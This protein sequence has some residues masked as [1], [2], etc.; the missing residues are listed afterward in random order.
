MKKSA[1]ENTLNNFLGWME[2]YI[3]ISDK[4]IKEKS[5]FT[6]REEKIEL[7]ESL[8][9]KICAQW[10]VLIEELVVDC[11]NRDSSQYSE[12]LASKLPKHIP[13]A[14]CHAMIQGLGYV[15]FKGV[16]DIKRKAKLILTDEY[17]PFKKIA[18]GD[19]DKIDELYK[20]RN[21]IA[22]LSNQ[23]ERSLKNVYFKKYHMKRFQEPGR[24]LMALDNKSKKPRLGIY[25][26]ALYSAVDDMAEDLGLVKEHDS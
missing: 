26:E 20:F 14:Q 7:I 15:D 25:I 4:I 21:Y 12:Y 19:G 2:V 9:L 3:G 10:E 6:E 22:H 18:K 8:V 13:R 24:F 11:L 1:I 17:N 23:A 16:G 5:L